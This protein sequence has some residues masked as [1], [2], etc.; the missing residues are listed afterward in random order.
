MTLRSGQEHF[1]SEDK[2]LPLHLIDFWR[3]SHSNLLS[4]TLRG[5][6]AEFIVASAIG[7]ENTQRTE[8]DAYD[9]LTP[10]GL[11]LEIKSSAYL[12]SWEQKK[13]S[14]IRFGISE[15]LGWDA[16]NN[17]TSTTPIRQADLYAFCLYNHKDRETANPLNLDQWVF[18]LLPT[19]LLND[20]LFKQKTITLPSLLKLQPIQCAYNQLKTIVNNFES[21]LLNLDGN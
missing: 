11:K 18:Y 14:I 20:N 3:W 19:A 10:K 6:L 7:L 12:Q 5:I 21:K 2:A 1:Y 15:T 17:T 8:W 4:N 9:L 13:D 16:I